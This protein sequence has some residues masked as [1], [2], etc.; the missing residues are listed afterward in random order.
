MNLN[1]HL[2]ELVAPATALAAILVLLFGPIF[3]PRAYIW[4]LLTYFTT[5]LYISINHFLKF[6][7]TVRNIKR[8]IRDWNVRQEHQSASRDYNTKEVVKSSATINGR[9][10][11]TRNG[12]TS[13]SMSN[14]LECDNRCNEMESALKL[15]DEGHYIHAFVIPNYEEPEPLLRDTIKRLAQHRFDF[16]AFFVFP[17]P[18]TSYYTDDDHHHIRSCS[19][20]YRLFILLT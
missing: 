14:N 12:Y 18:L 6:C 11:P 9:I 4:F 5:F 17:P 2:F 16:V 8:N 13:V 19:H 15:Y 20:Y 10:T 3:F 1:N 7:I